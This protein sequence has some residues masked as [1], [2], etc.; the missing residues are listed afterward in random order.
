MLKN[1]D[2]IA[3]FLRVA[4]GEVICVALML[5]VYAL[6]GRLSPAVL[7]GAL[8]GAAVAIGNFLALSITVT[9]AADRAAETGDAA[10][11][12]LSVRA[13]AVWR[14]LAMAVILILVLRTGVCD[15]LAAVL[16]LIFIQISIS[17]MEFF[18]KDGEKRQCR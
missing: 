16:P 10:K 11:A 14:L 13:S 15:P 6:I 18:R 12:T 8:L 1:K 2:V 9:R 17:L 5:G 4:L 7:W 3:Q